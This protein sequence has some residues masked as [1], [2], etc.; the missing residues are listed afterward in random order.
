MACGL[1]VED[2]GERCLL[3]PSGFTACFLGEVTYMWL[4]RTFL[5]GDE[6]LISGALR[7]GVNSPP[8][9]FILVQNETIA[10]STLALTGVT[11]LPLHLGGIAM[12]HRACR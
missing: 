6:D 4:I 12:K 3:G 5:P 8:C 11:Q 2:L 1:T 10:E 7:Q 9:Q